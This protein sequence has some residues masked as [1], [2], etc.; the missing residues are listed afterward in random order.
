MAVFR[1]HC[2]PGLRNLLAEMDVS[3]TVITAVPARV[4]G[5]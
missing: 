1:S 4:E 3:E 2:R 5:R